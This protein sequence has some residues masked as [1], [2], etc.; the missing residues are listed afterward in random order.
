MKKV[1]IPSLLLLSLVSLTACGDSGL[2]KGGKA[3][4]DGDAAGRE[5]CLT[6]QQDGADTLGKQLFRGGKVSLYGIQ[7]V[8]ARQRGQRE[9]FGITRSLWVNFNT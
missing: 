8:I 6:T 7:L 9:R 3:Y 5:R 1:F 4:R 2:V